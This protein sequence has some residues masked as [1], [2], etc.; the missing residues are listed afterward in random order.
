M[1]VYI[2]VHCAGL[3]DVQNISAYTDISRQTEDHSFSDHLS[4]ESVHVTPSCVTE[5][6]IML[7]SVTF[8]TRVSQCPISLR[9]E[10]LIH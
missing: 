3:L 6:S 5:A 9:S 1:V 7:C 10:H 8:M 2:G 4:S